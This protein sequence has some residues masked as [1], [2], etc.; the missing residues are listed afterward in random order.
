MT[1]EAIGECSA[2]DREWASLMLDV[3]L[4]DPVSW[5]MDV[6]SLRL[7]CHALP[8]PPQLLG[9]QSHFKAAKS[10]GKGSK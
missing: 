6:S 7:D 4:R 10:C 9:I 8:W 2:E 3:V 1:L 5:M